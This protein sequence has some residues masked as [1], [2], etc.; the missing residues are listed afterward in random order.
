M[1][2]LI[3]N[4]I[5]GWLGIVLFLLLQCGVHFCFAV[6]SREKCLPVMRYVLQAIALIIILLYFIFYLNNGLVFC[7]FSIVPFLW[8]KHGERKKGN[9]A[10][11]YLCAAVVSILLLFLLNHM[12]ILE[13]F[14]VTLILGGIT[15]C[16]DSL[17]TI[18]MWRI[19][20]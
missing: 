17:V 2:N 1:F 14:L 5:G 15:A 10:L 20:L 8:I 19:K 3:L 9:L 18:L 16:I 11:L 12:P 7:I 6:S 13:A 4:D